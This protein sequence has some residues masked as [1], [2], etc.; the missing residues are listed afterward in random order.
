MKMQKLEEA[1]KRAIM[2]TD[3]F[4]KQLVR[5][6]FKEEENSDVQFAKKYIFLGDVVSYEECPESIFPEYDGPVIYIVGMHECYYIT[7]NLSDF[8]KLIDEYIKGLRED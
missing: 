3:G 5:R 8:D 6:I 2:K 7:G 1:G 4:T